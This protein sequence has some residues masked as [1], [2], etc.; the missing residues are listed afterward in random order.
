MCSDS[1]ENHNP[2][3]VALIGGSTV[4]QRSPNERAVGTEVE[5]VADGPEQAFVQSYLNAER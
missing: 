3:W 5:I 1:E 4:E 2:G